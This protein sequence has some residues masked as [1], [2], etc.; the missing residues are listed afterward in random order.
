[1]LSAVALD[2]CWRRFKR[3]YGG[4][5]HLTSLLLW[6]FIK[7]HARLW[8]RFS[9]CLDDAHVFKSVAL[10]FSPIN[11]TIMRNCS[12]ISCC[13][14]A[15]ESLF[16]SSTVN[17]PPLKNLSLHTVSLFCIQ[18]FSM[19]RQ[20]TTTSCRKKRLRT[21]N[22]S[23]PILRQWIYFTSFHSEERLPKRCW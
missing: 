6:S 16:K 12:I 14:I 19:Q 3:V 23:Y 11:N 1:M 7:L 18:L 22:A 21:S 2:W 17:A 13:S 4:G 9:H 8:S 20:S 5:E 10:D 15:L